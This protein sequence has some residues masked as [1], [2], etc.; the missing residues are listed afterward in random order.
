MQ[1]K[2]TIELS[3]EIPDRIVAAAEALFAAKGVEAVSLRELTSI[4]GVSLGAV[5]YYFGS[6][7]A[8]TDTVY[9]K[10]CDRINSIRLAELDVALAEAKRLKKKPALDAILKSFVRPYLDPGYEKS[11]LLLARLILEHRLRPSALTQRLYDK[12]LDHLANRYIDA[13]SEASPKVPLT[14]I[15]WRYSFMVNT[16][17]LTATDRDKH[18]RLKKLSKGRAD[19]GDSKKLERA[20]LSFLTRGFLGD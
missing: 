3:G 8:L 16:V 5:N 17:V 14:E 10:L 11:G 20:L 18:N 7:E 12:H 15:F 9:T 19:S 2:V 6:K 1:Y 4:A 13:L